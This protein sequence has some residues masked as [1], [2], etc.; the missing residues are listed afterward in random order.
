[1]FDMLNVNNNILGNRSVDPTT[2]YLYIIIY[3]NL[4]C[5]T[6]NWHYI[7]TIIIDFVM[8]VCILK[9]LAPVVIIIGILIP[10]SMLLYNL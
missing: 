6:C 9:T 8:V 5:C 2:V 3:K 10:K 1:M 7:L 4:F